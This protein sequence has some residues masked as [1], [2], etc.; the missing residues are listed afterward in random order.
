MGGTASADGGRLE[1]V[2]ATAP[3]TASFQGGGTE[4]GPEVPGSPREM[5]ISP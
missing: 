5:F 2:K 3:A 1:E 4:T